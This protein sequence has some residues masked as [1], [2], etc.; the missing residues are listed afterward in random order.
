VAHREIGQMAR[1]EE[2]VRKA[3]EL[4]PRDADAQFLLATILFGRS[5]KAARPEFQ[6]VTEMAP[7]RADGWFWLGACYTALSLR[8]DAVVSFERAVELAP[9]NG[10][11][12]RELGKALLEENKLEPA[13]THLAKAVELLPQDPAAAYYQGKALLATARTGAEFQEADRRLEKALQLLRE[14]GAQNPVGVAEIT[15]ERA[16]AQQRLGNLSLAEALLQEARRHDP[17]RLS[18]LYQLAEVTRARG[19]EEAARR[20]MRE[21]NSRV[22]IDNQAFELNQRIKQDSRNPD[23]RL[24]L[25]RLLVQ[26]KD[27]SGALLQYQQCLLLAPERADVKLEMERLRKSMSKRAD[28]APQRR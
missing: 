26:G 10:E 15:A 21:Y 11:Y 9:E 18:Y 17:N 22:Q 16:A 6:K 8:S 14:S 1:A 5:P 12:R 23:L 27:Y 3:I 28:S 20:L 13:Q 7:N 4:E 19:D 24:R 25:A 2:T